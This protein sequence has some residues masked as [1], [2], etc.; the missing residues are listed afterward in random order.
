MFVDCGH[1][2]CV[3]FGCRL[4]AYL[5]GSRVYVTFWCTLESLC[6]KCFLVIWYSLSTASFAYSTDQSTKWC[7]YGGTK[8][9]SNRS[10]IVQLG[11]PDHSGKLSRRY[12]SSTRRRTVFPQSWGVNG[13]RW[14][15]WYVLLL[16]SFYGSCGFILWWQNHTKLVPR[17]HWS[18]CIHQF[19]C[20]KLSDESNAVLKTSTLVNGRGAV[21]GRA[22]S[23][24]SASAWPVSILNLPVLGL[25]V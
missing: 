12:I 23:K 18:F 3:D 6:D 14:Y 8:W 7:F 25:R 16:E 15:L 1:R 17:S 5:S 22:N 21:S 4:R 2:L 19:L 11:F 13:M 20:I 10:D 9:G 24:F